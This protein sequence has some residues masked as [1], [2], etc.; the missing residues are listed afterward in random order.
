MFSSAIRRN[1]RKR[2]P[3]ESC[4]FNTDAQGATAD[5]TQLMQRFQAIEASLG[6]TVDELFKPKV[7]VDEL[8]E[9]VLRVSDVYTNRQPLTWN[10][11]RTYTWDELKLM[12]WS[13][14]LK[15]KPKEVS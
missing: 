8:R 13:Q 5:L 1:M 7:E 3:I 12:T 10:G 6:K 4:K 11:V 2:G 9:D 15:A 14:V